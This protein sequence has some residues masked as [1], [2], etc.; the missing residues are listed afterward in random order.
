MTHPPAHPWGPLAGDGRGALITGSASGIGRGLAES[1]AEA[2]YRVA[3]ADVD[4]Q[5]GQATTQAVRDAGGDACFVHMNVAEEASVAAGIAEIRERWGALDFVLNNAGVVGQ[6]RKIDQLDE[7]DLDRVLAIN[8]KGPFL[9]CK[10]AV[11]AMGPKGGSIVNLSSITG[12]NG[13]PYFTAYGASKAG[14][15]AL[16]KGIARNLGR[17][18]IRVNCIRPG[19]IGGTGLMDDFYQDHPEARLKDSRGLKMKIPVGRVGQAK[20]VA[21]LALFLASPL[22]RHLNGEVLTLDG[23][24]RYGFQ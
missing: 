20:D 16:T 13:S 9:V 3:I 2:G 6:C 1:F 15:E 21:S 4:R 17:F 23:G 10:H 19:S 8:L 24:E 18:N 12:C 22:A 7:A 11:R 5:T 14:V